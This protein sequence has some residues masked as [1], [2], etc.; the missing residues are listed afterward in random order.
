MEETSLGI[1]D[2]RLSHR[3]V[4]GF[5]VL[6]MKRVSNG[7]VKGLSRGIDGSRRKV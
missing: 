1:P 7:S 2:D 4:K 3:L 6:S 5:Y